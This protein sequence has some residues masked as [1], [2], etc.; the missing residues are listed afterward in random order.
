[1]IEATGHG[2]RSTSAQDPTRRGVGRLFWLTSDAIVAA[3]IETGAIVLWNPAATRLFE[4]E[5]DEALGMPLAALVP[6]E[7]ADRH[8]AGVDRYRG[9]ARPVLVGGPPV[10]VP[11]VTKSGR[12]VEVGL[13]L[14]DVTDASD[15][16]GRYFVLA[17]I[18]DMT[19]IRAS[20]REVRSAM[21]ALEGFVAAAS[22][23]LRS[24][25]TSVMGFAAALLD[26]D[27]RDTAVDRRR[28]AEAIVR[29]ATQAC[30]LVDDLLT[31]SEI[32]GGAL[33]VAARAVPVAD[34]FAT[35]LEQSG[36]TATFEADAQLTVWVDPH[37][38]ER[39]LVNYLNNAGR[40]GAGP[41]VVTARADGGMVDVAV[42]DSGPGVP[43]EFVP[44]LFTR[45]ARAH[46][47]TTLGT[48][49]GLSIVLGLARANGG[50]AYYRA[51]A[52]GPIFGV[53]LPAPTVC[54]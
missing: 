40:H 43:A 32:Q 25:L 14:T 39:I 34:A 10:D 26:A 38:L 22:H 19:A 31:L 49:L 2:P 44:R 1:M 12:I 3:D 8:L 42:R 51:S 6:P 27:D 16:T 5:A 33:P 15:G 4:Y 20:E 9:G 7:L 36:V 29:G 46:G 28:F 30:R 37:H 53:H 45:F 18:R 52:D 24:P 47:S 21:D 54:P 48:G 13:T 35:A 17:V 23:D 11:A 50:D 41:I